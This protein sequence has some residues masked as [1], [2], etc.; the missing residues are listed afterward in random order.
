VI[1]NNGT[2]DLITSTTNNKITTTTAKSCL[3]N[4]ESGISLDGM[5]LNNNNMSTTISQNSS[6]VPLINSDSASKPQGGI[7]ENVSKLFSFL[8]VLTAVFGS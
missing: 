6:R 3:Q 8:Q 7:D 4:V 5:L 2:N 1:L